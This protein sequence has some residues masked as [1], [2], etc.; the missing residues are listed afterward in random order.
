MSL[1]WRLL[2]VFAVLG[3]VAIGAATLSAWLSTGNELRDEVDSFLL[4]R[5]EEILRGQ[6]RLP[7]GACEPVGRGRPPGAPESFAPDVVTQVLTEDGAVCRSVGDELPVDDEDRAVAAGGADDPTRLRTV[8]VDGVDL[9]VLTVHLREGGAF[10]IA[11]DLTETDDV[12][13][14]L[15]GRMVL[16]TLAGA[17]LAGG[18]G[19]LVAVRLTRPVRALADTAE[20]VAATQDL[21]TTI[22][23][24]GSDEVA[25][26]AQSFNTMLTALAQSRSQ[27]QQLI[28]D[29]SHELRTPLTSLRTSA[30]LLE[31]ARDLDPEERDRLLAVVA[32]ESR[33]L[34]DLVT[35]LV[36]LA[37][38]QRAPAPFTDVAFGDVVDRVVHLWAERVDRPISASI[39]A[40]TVAG[41]AALLERVVRNLLDNAD[42]FSPAGEEVEVTLV[43]VDGR[44]VLRVADHGPGVPV[45][46]RDRIFVR[47]FRGRGEAVLRTSGVGIGLAVVKDFVTQMGGAI[48]VD[49]SP[50]GGA[51]FIV[52]LPV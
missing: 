24:Q 51:R 38:E 22:P 41:D 3:A 42:K 4:R 46:E 39:A 26:L 12:L 48:E 7:V 37:T 36:E 2:A 40:V 34:G 11:R 15:G 14:D 8:T 9:R 33:E 49:A 16:I 20:Q 19:W 6:R 17:A 30:E 18:V 35:E 21:S 29:A 13:S 44:A 31:R 50:G 27:Q 1:R 47:F 43:V 45:E 52:R 32:S 28:Q 10:Q 5:G 23:V 25:R